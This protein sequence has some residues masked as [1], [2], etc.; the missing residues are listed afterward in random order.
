[1]YYKKVN[2]NSNKECFEFLA[3][4]FT[5]DTLNSWNGLKSIAN[6]VKLY[7]I[8]ELDTGLVLEA[9]QEDYYET[10]NQTIEDWNHDHPDFQVAFNGRSGG[11]LVLYS[12]HHNGHCFNES[13]YCSPCCHFDDYEEWKKCVQHEW[14]SL[15][16][17]HSSLVWQVTTVQDFDKLCDDL[18]EVVKQ[19]VQDMVDRKSHTFEFEATKRFERYDYEDKTNLHYHMEYMKQRGYSV[20][21]YDEDDLWAEYE[22]N[23]SVIGDVVLMIDPED[24]VE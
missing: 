13:D 24:L 15:K 1:M 16:A 21:E 4:H 10:I 5:Y 7:N 8:P 17:Y 9:L 18:V 19:L 3:N 23:E 14:G 2:L 22:M 6:N 11:Y 12:K 20:Y